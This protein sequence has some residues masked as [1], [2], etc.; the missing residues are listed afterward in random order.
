MDKGILHI[1]RNVPFGKETLLSSIYFSKKIDSELFVYIPRYRKFNMYF[2]N[3][4]VQVTLDPS[5]LKDQDLAEKRVLDII[6]RE[7]AFASILKVEDFSASTLPDLP[8]DF[9]FMTCPRVISDIL[10]KIYPGQIGPTVRRILLNARFPVFLPSP[11]F[12]PWKSLVVMFGGSNTSINALSLG[13]AIA[14][15]TDLPLFLF[16]QSEGKSQSWYEDIICNEIKSY[17]IFEQV[18]EWYFFEN[19]ELETNLFNVPHNAMLLAGIFGHSL[20]KGLVFGG[21][22]ELMQSILPNNF[23]LVGPNFLLK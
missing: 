3:Q 22:I 16:T 4:A 13:Y 10:K 20:I 19:G 11:V 12:K 14:Q 7:G 23:L 17:D 1:Y 6:K 18:K 21:K 9:S 5:Y 15:K 8:T 2:D